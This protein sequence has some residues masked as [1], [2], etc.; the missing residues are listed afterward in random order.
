MRKAA[1]GIVAKLRQCG[2]EALFAGGWVRDF[3]LGRKAKDIDIATN[4]P[5]EAVQ[6]L[7]PGSKAI[8]AAFG[9]VQVRRHGHTFEVA[10]FRRDHD[11]RDGR[12]P[13]KVTFSTAEEDAARRDFTVNGLFYDPMGER[14]IDYVGGQDDL[15]RKILR[16]IGDAPRRFAED[17]LRML[18]AVRFACELG[19]EIEQKTWEAVKTFSRDI[20][21]VS[22]ERIR[23]EFFKVLTGTDPGKGLNLLREGGLLAQILPETVW[24]R[25]DAAFTVARDA[26]AALRHPSPSLAAGALLHGCV[27]GGADVEL[28][29]RQLRM[30]GG[31]IARTVALVSSLNIF[32][33]PD[34]LAQSAK[35][36]LLGK[37]DI[38][39]HLE[40]LRARLIA[41]GQSL[42]PYAS[43]RREL[44]AWRR[45]P[46][47][48]PLVD[49]DDLVALGYQPGPLFRE[50]LRATEDLQYEGE[51]TTRPEALH[52]IQ[53]HWGT[54][55]KPAD[56]A[57]PKREKRSLL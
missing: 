20:S 6:G 9:V 10:T 28:I 19:F 15:R 14:L 26:V 32:A 46:P 2:Y 3:L 12:H 11:Y 38:R 54:S 31:E 52:Y 33:A 49:G 30:S 18:R 43:W 23:D 5:P 45:F 39:E 13:E 29:C 16:A 56:K 42:A 57:P 35:I 37:P 40:L 25:D 51:L 53:S 21:V 44:Q 55:K 17:K 27:G 48:P 47:P 36:R 41:G 24:L 4:A 8:G 1:V 34:A 22:R 50:I 7:F